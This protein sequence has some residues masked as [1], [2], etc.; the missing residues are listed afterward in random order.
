[1][2]LLII[3]ITC[4]NDFL[5][6]YLDTYEEGMQK[7]CLAEDTSNIDETGV[8]SNEVRERGKKR[9]R[10][11]AK[12]YMSSSSEDDLC[13]YKENYSITQEKNLPALPHKQHFVSNDKELLS[14]STQA[15]RDILCENTFN[16][17]SR[18]GEH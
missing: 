14:T 3:F 17:V 2:Y 8:S 7:L 6:N 5:V 4:F 15:T 1:M 10:I 11:K 18:N 9:R 13:S 12:K 16:A